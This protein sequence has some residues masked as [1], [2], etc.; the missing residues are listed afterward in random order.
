MFLVVDH[1]RADEPWLALTGD[2]LFVGDTARPDLAVG[3]EE[4][5]RVLYHSL[6]ERLLALADGVEVFPGHVAG[7]LCGRGMNAKPSTTIG[8]ERRFNPMLT[9]S[10]EDGFVEAA[11]RELLPKP[12]NL[13]TIVALNSGPFRARPERPTR[14]AEVPAGAPLLDVRPSAAFAAGHARGALHVPADGTG[15]GNRAGWL[16]AADDEPVLVADDEATALHAARLLQ[17]V[18]LLRQGGWV[19]SEQAGRSEDFAV[20]DLDGML[21]GV[22]DGTLQLLDVREADERPQALERA[23]LVP[24][25]LLESA[26]LGGLDPDRPTAVVCG[27]GARAPIG[28][29][30][31]ARRGFRDTR[32]VLA[33]GMARLPLGVV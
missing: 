14:L 20:L 27:T 8:F 11:N 7:S 33:G 4:G 22:R 25:R 18:G 1:T 31:L 23:L 12:P 5:A 19:T 28:A 26:D 6:H 30:I 17:A 3:G 15:F 10:T 29:A 24:L 21:A 16:L 9:I 13:T 32:P 2:S